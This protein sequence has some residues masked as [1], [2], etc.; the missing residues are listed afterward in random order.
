MRDSDCTQPAQ[1]LDSGDRLVV[2]QAHAVPEHIAL[3]ML[4]Q[5]SPLADGKC[6]GCANA[7]Q[8]GLVFAE[9]VMKAVLLHLREHC[10][11]LTIISHVLAL[12]ATDW[13]CLRRL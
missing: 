10:P 9:C 7:N 11:L 4:Y 12:V 13:A 5:Q 3:W 6:G 1:A 2:D 8:S